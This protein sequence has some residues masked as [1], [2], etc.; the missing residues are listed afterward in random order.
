MAMRESRN[1]ILETIHKIHGP[2]TEAGAVVCS[3]AL[4]QMVRLG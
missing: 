4:E 3:V 1:V 2:Q